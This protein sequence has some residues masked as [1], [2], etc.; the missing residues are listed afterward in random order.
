[1]QEGFEG[2]VLIDLDGLGLLFDLFDVGGCDEFG[3]FVCG[4]DVMF[5]ILWWQWSMLWCLD[6]FCCEGVSN[7]LYDLCLLL[8]V[9]IVCF[10]I[11][12]VCWIGDII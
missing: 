10:E 5:Q 2:M 12:D 1:M 6:Y 7:F 8:I 11:F 4:I 3:Q 9:I